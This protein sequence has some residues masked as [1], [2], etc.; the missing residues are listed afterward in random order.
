M[1]SDGL[2]TIVYSNVNCLE[3]LSKATCIYGDGTFYS[4]PYLWYQLFILHASIDGCAVPC[5]YE[6]LPDKKERSY[7]DFFD[8]LKLALNHNNLYMN[9][10]F[11]I[12]DFEFNIPKA[13]SKYFPEIETRGCY[14]HFTKGKTLFMNIVILVFPNFM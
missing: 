11:F 12:S 9:A 13:F 3:I 6:L 7:N 1:H 4:C 14:F 2:R 10:D 5:A 8:S